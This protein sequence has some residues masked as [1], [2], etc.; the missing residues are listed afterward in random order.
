MALQRVIGGLLSDLAQD[1]GTTGRRLS[2]GTTEFEMDEQ[3]VLPPNLQKPELMVGVRGMIE[4]IGTPSE[5]DQKKLTLAE[6]MFKRGE[7]NEDIL[8][9]TGFMFDPNGRVQKEID[10]VDAQFLLDPS[11]VKKGKAYKME[12]VFQHPSLFDFYPK[13]KGMEVKFYD[14][15]PKE[16]GEFN[17]VTQTIMI[18]RNNINFI[19]GNV[20]EIIS[21]VLHET[22]HAIQQLEKF[23]VG[24]NFTSFLNKPLEMATQE[25]IEKAG[26]KYLSIY[27]EAEARNVE[28]RYLLKQAAKALKKPSSI[29]G[30]NFLRTLTQ[31]PLSRNYGIKPEQL[32]TPRG[33]T[34]DIRSEEFAPMIP[35]RTI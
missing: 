17:P 19:D 12:E 15:P 24:G 34:V 25:E 6:N 2:R 3:A 8:A 21:T 23:I 27:G 31:D 14:G 13:F 26:R 10:D 30:Q 16:K 20:P 33:Q 18:N 29:E 32:T 5:V 7:A 4:A 28:F 1:F 35:E 22:Q 9:K 11:E